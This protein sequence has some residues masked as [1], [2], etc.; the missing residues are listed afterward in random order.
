MALNQMTTY[1]G[2][3]LG[4]PIWAASM[5]SVATINYSLNKFAESAWQGRT[6]KY[7]AAYHLYYGQGEPGHRSQA[8]W[9]SAIWPIVHNKQL[10]KERL[11]AAIDNL[12]RRHCDKFWTIGADE[13]AHYIASTGLWWTG[14][15]GLNPKM[16]QTISDEYRAELYRTDIAQAMETICDSMR[17]EA[18]EESYRAMERYQK[19]MNKVITISFKDGALKNDSS[20]YAGCTVRFANLP[21]NIEDPQLWETTLN[22]E[23]KGY[24][25]FRILSQVYNK[26]EP[27]MV[28]VNSRGAILKR[29]DLELD[30]K[31]VVDLSQDYMLGF[32]PKF[33]DDMKL[34]VV[35]TPDSL[36]WENGVTRGGYWENNL[37]TG[38]RQ[39]R[40]H[41]AEFAAG[42]L[43]IYFRDLYGDIVELMKEHSALLAQ[44]PSANMRI[45]VNGLSLNGTYDTKTKTGSGQF[46]INCDYEPSIAT[47][48]DWKTFLWDLLE[49]K[50]K[51]KVFLGVE[52]I[53]G[54]RQGTINALLGGRMAHELRGTYEVRETKS[55]KM[56]YTFNGAGTYQLDAQVM[57]GFENVDFQMFPKLMKQP[58]AE[59]IVQERTFN[60][61]CTIDQSFVFGK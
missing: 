20:K 57:G 5:F 15:G 40:E 45:D 42:W 34:N 2:K 29:L 53:D 6:D 8:D 35:M 60:G 23:G 19:M 33:P 1:A 50:L 3:F 22:K 17:Y 36:Y 30:Y 55:G 47:S 9:V 21:S 11:D 44:T 58:D 13:Q 18:F 16:E 52:E 7:R 37:A 32:D 54:K 39:Y 31:T 51:H 25:Q 56:V 10:T 4:G 59:V 38:E 26:V 12:V 46:T 41:E 27:R 48:D 49:G 14:W 24:I 28:V 43:R 61:Q